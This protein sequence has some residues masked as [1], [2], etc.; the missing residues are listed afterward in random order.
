MNL[1]KCIYCKM[2][3]GNNEA[4]FKVSVYGCPLIANVTFANMIETCLGAK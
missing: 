1:I 4:K 3:V 2:Y